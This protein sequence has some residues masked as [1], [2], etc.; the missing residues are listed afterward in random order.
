MA[1][2]AYRFVGSSGSYW[3]GHCQSSSRVSRSHS[4]DD[5]AAVARI[6]FYAKQE[7]ILRSRKLNYC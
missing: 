4:L 2:Q 6:E 5:D 3:S 7:G 1:R